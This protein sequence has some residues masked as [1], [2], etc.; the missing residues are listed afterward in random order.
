MAISLVGSSVIVRNG[1]IEA[2]FPGGMKSF[3]SSCPNQTFCTD[4][5]ISR[6][7]FMVTDDARIFISRLV[8]AGLAS[9]V[10]E[11]R[12]EIALVTQGQGFDYPCDWLQLG[13]F[14]GHPCA[15]LAGSDRGSLFIPEFDLNSKIVTT[16]AEE[17]RESFEFVGLKANGKVAVYRH[18][19][20]G[21]IR[22]LGRPFHPAHKWW[23]FWKRPAQFPVNRSNHDE[24]FEAACNLIKPYIEHQL[25][26]APLD[27]AARKQLKRAREILGRIIEFNP[28]NWAA[29]WAVGIANKCLRDLA[30]AYAAFQMAYALEKENPNVGRELSGI[31]MAL[32]K[33]EEAVR[34]SR[35]VVDRNPQNA[36]LISNHALALLI[37]GNIH[38]AEIAVESALRLEPDDQITRS[39]AKFIAAVRTNQAPRPDR[40]PP[41]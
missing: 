9:S 28:S 29:L 14:D 5:N 33:A 16:S 19:K 18:K 36:S 34:I 30:A 11:A 10:A 32:G 27:R 13:L 38:E 25:T 3:V 37:A 20:T 12:T 41:T 40:Y 35:E 39:L 31:C 23:Q 22:Y 26:D 4:G 24:I 17:F 8:D 1:T 15:W 6:V 2:R 7:A 21:E